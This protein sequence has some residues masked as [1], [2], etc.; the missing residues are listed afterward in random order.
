MWFLGSEAVSVKIKLILMI[1]AAK[2]SFK[3]KRNL[4]FLSKKLLFIFQLIFLHNFPSPK[5]LK[6]D[7]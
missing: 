7:Y 2:K 3:R 5:G 6:N 1:I 4:M